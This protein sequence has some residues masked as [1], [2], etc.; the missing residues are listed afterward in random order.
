[1]RNNQPQEVEAMSLIHISV[2]GPTY[3]LTANKQFRFEDH[4]HCGPVVVGK[5]DDPLEPQPPASSTFWT[6]VN[7]WYQQGKKFKEV[8]GQRW[9]IY[10]TQM[11]EARRICADERKANPPTPQQAQVSTK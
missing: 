4:P 9:C 3:N 8:D 11:Q 1:M 5:K 7:A 10:Q 2:G 6:H